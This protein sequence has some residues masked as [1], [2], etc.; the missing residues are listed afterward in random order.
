[1]APA[2]LKVPRM[3]LQ[4]SPSKSVSNTGGVRIRRLLSSEY[5]TPMVT[6]REGAKLFHSRVMSMPEYT[7]EGVG[8]LVE[9]AFISSPLTDNGERIDKDRVRRIL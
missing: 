1:M 2:G 3:T 7:D 8:D 4:K 5:Q 9:D 6:E